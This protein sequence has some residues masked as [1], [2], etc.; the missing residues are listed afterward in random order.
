[1][2]NNG[3]KD[4]IYVVFLYLCNVKSYINTE[5][6]LFLADITKNE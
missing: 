1:M 2:N 4:V 6:H 3:K 5:S